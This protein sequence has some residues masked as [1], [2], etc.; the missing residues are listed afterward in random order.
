MIGVG[1]RGRVEP[2]E[3]LVREHRR[4]SATST[5]R[6]SSGPPQG[7]PRPGSVAISARSTTTPNEFDAVVVSTT[8][9]T[10]AFATL[11][12]LQ[13]GKHVYC[14]KPLTHNVWEARVIREAAAAAKV[15]TQMGTQIHA[16]DNYRRVVELIQTGAIG[17]VR[18]VHV[19]VGR[20]WG[21]QSEEDAKK[22]GDIVSVRERPAGLVAGPEGARLGPLARPRAG[23]A[24]P[25]GLLARAQVVSMVGFRQRH[26][27][28]PG[29]ALDRPAVLGSQAAGAQDDRGVRPAARIPRSPRP[30]CTWSTNTPHEG[31]QP[32]LQLTWYQGADKPEPGTAG[33]I[34][35]WDSGVLF[36]GS[37]GMLL[38]DYGRHV[39]LPE[40]E[41]RDFK[42]PEP[43]IPKSLGH[44]AEWIHACKTGRADD[45]RLRLLGLADRGESPGERRLPRGQEARVGRREALRPQR[46][47]GRAA[48][49]AGVPQGLDAELSGPDQPTP[50]GDAVRNR[51]VARALAVAFYCSLPRLRPRQES[52][53]PRPRAARLAGRPHDGPGHETTC[54]SSSKTIDEAMKPL[55]VNVVVLEV[56]YGFEYQSHP[57][58]RRGQG[59]TRADARD[60]AAFCRERGSG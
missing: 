32:A 50:G 14:E 59:W 8:E 55:G 6:P 40:K 26:H 30:R 25:R 23:P 1:G 18:E 2:R 5:N 3:R 17:P 42:R 46:P 24:V 12:A 27:E 34:P 35:K 36:V 48:H 13:L 31:E 51:S 58:L 29:I 39:L 22:N 21:R 19:W 43:F 10:H 45:L 47:G 53:R 11:P 7:I 52:R 56:N 33:A 28:R 37:K 41:F 44:H 57:E 20:A 4:R 15:A 54:R 16:G 9:H 38:S 49:P 60:L